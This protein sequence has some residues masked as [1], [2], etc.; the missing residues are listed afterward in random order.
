M[1]ARNV[2]VGIMNTA[3]TKTKYEVGDIIQANVLFGGRYI[4]IVGYVSGIGMNT[5]K[6]RRYHIEAGLGTPIV[7]YE[8]DIKMPSW[9]VFTSFL[10]L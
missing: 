6:S 8:K 9:E 7:V 4:D 2:Q 10:G 3:E 1:Y 5:E